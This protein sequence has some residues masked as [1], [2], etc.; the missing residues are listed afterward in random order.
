MKRISL[1]FFLFLFSLIVKS[2]VLNV[3]K[4]SEKARKNYI[5]SIKNNSEIVFYI[6]SELQK[7]GLPKHLRNLALIE[8]HFQKNTTS[9]AGAKG[10]WQLMVSHANRFGLTDEKRTDIYKSTKVAINSLAY[11]YKKY[12]NWITVV[13]SYNCGEG[14]I[15]EAMNKA[16]STEYLDFYKYLPKE[17]INHV[18]KYID[19]CYATNELDELLKDFNNKNIHL[20]K[21]AINLTTININLAYDLD[22]IADSL[23]ISEEQIIEWNRSLIKNLREKGEAELSLPYDYMIIFIANKQQILKDSLNKL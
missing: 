22:I 8:S 20:K 9:S 23:N 6:E 19:A 7:K 15:R 10:I 1:F 5:N 16:N 18:Q 17:T 4:D 12:N 3:S 2:Q 14:N 11:L 21:D 13:A